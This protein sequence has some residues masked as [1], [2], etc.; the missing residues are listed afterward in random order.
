MDHAPFDFTDTSHSDLVGGRSPWGGEARRPR[1]QAFEDSFKV[2]VAIIGGGITGALTAQNLT[3]LGFSV[4]VIDRERPGLGSTS[5]STA[6]LEWEID[7]PLTELAGYYGFERA[8]AIYR[9]SHAAVSGL[10]TLMAS[11][12]ID[13][14]FRPRPTLYITG[15]EQAPDSLIEEMLLRERAGL[16]GRFLPSAEL[17]AL[18]GIHRAGAIHSPGSAEADPLRMAWGLL[19]WS[20]AHGARLI[21]ATATAFHEEGGRVTVETDTPYVI[22]ARHV[23]LATGY[24]MPGF[25]MP[26]I[27]RIASSWAVATEPQPAD[28]LW[29]ERALIWEAS[30]PYLYM[31]TT[32]DNRIVIGG[33]DEAIDD[34]TLRDAKLPA[35]AQALSEK[36]QRLW[37]AARPVLSHAWCGAFGETEDGLPLIGRVPGTQSLFAAYGY[38]GNGITFSYMAAQM[39][40]AF[41]RGDWRNW[42]DDFA[43]D[44]PSPG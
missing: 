5:A 26:E 41:A 38:G 9:R 36:L 29:P 42:F 24:V 34:P 18:F 37:P 17:A 23:V 43:L 11:L 40:G 25:V 21:D 39:A 22:E 1:S 35:K 33:E 32:V 12:G 6:M 31:R 44:R 8:S 14:A 15:E 30:E 20:A 28:A 10:S 4:C 7:A 13:C 27:H 19:H 3:A 16:P 2:D